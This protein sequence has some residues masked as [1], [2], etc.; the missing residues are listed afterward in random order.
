MPT[1]DFRT[2]NTRKLHFFPASLSDET[3]LSRLSRYH[4]LSA[5]REDEH[6]FQLLFSEPGDQANFAAAAPTPLRRLANQLPG[7]SRKNLGELLAFNT[8]VPLVAPVL[9]SLRMAPS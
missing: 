9:A 1:F 3:L 2:S 4:L 6:T 8:F 7:Q 5:A